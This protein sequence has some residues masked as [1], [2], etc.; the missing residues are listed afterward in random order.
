MATLCSKCKKRP[1]IV[2]VQRM[3]MAGKVQNEGYCILCA[4][5]LGIKPVT[6]MIEKM[7]IDEEQ[8]DSLSEEMEN[9]MNEGGMF[10]MDMDA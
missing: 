1:A 4:K 7:G 2:F 3:D 9:I 5:D 6:D 10:G 8:L